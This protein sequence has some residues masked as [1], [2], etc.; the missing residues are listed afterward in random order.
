VKPA[1]PVRAEAEA[2][3]RLVTTNALGARLG[4]EPGNATLAIEGRLFGEF[5]SAVSLNSLKGMGD[6]SR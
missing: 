5:L 1:V 3:R 6:L 4:A 2:R